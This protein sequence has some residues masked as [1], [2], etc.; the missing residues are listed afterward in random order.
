MNIYVK[1]SVGLACFIYAYLA[2]QIR[3]GAA[4]QNI[5]TWVSFALLDIV[6]GISLHNQHGN[7][8]LFLIYT[9]GSS[10]I[11]LCIFG[12]AKVTWNW[13]EKTCVGLV[14]A[15]IAIWILLGAQYATVLSTIGMA[16]AA[17]PQFKDAIQ[18]VSTAP[19]GVYL[20]F[21]IVNGLA[22]AGGKNWSID[23]RFCPGVCT[24][25]CIML[26]CITSRKLFLASP[27]S[28]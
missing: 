8:H 28:A 9:M 26:V 7:W 20:G 11:V 25:L 13:V 2:Y 19:L 10:T 4:K 18:D 16:I 14:V 22:T 12:S 23:E 15:A 6:A 21:M 17:Y 27:R 3:K 24:V 5:A 1:L